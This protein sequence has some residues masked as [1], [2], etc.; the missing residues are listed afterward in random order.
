MRPFFFK[1]RANDGF[2]SSTFPVKY[3]KIILL[4]FQRIKTVQIVS[5]CQFLSNYF[6]YKLLS[7]PVHVNTIP[8]PDDQRSRPCFYD[9]VT[10][11][12]CF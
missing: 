5:N 12:R 8:C 4:F 11:E 6:N 10:R 2:F 7:L 9:M 1:S 3:F